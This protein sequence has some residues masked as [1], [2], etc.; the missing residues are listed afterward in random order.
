MEVKAY[1]IQAQGQPLEPFT[2]TRRAPGAEDV[3]IELM[4]CG[5][6]HTDLIIGNNETGGAMYP[7]VPGHEMV[8]TVVEAGADVN[9]V[10]VGDLVGIGCIADSCRSCNPCNDGDEH[11]CETGFSLSFNGEDKQG[12]KT[13]GGYSSHYTVNE[14]Y[15]VKIPDGLDPAA[16]A[17]LLCGGI[18]VYTPLK[19]FGAGP[20]KKVGVLGLGG[21][22]HLAIKIA[23]AMGAHTV[24]LTGSENKVGDAQKL[25]A[26]DV[27]LTRDPDALEAHAGSFDLIINT[28]SGNHDVNSFL[29]LLT[30]GGNMCF[31][32]APQSPAPI[33]IANLIMGDKLM[34]GSLIGGMP[35]TAEMLQF[36]ADHN[37]S[38]DIE[39]V[40]IAQVNEAWDRIEKSDVKYRFVIDLASLGQA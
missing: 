24:M 2:V 35:A 31:V 33:M 40:D 34:S 32:G 39:M 17:P 36:C 23:K 13:Y 29:P 22:G 6:C 38:A 3:L 30:R 26:D 28:I 16:A 1:A 14:R 37:I 19:R 18:T 11:Y 8:G 7:V 12:E 15:V 20:G 5:I 4:Y 27:V 21:L 9:T 10:A 25:G